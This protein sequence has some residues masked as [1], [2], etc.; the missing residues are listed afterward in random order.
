M[1]N[2]HQKSLCLTQAFA[3]RPTMPTKVSDR[4]WFPVHFRVFQHITAI[5]QRH[6]QAASEAYEN[7]H[8]LDHLLDSW[9]QEID[10]CSPSHAIIGYDDLLHDLSLIG[11]PAPPRLLKHL[12]NI[13]QGSSDAHQ[14][15][16]Q[17]CER[18]GFFHDPA[19]QHGR[20][21]AWTRLWPGSDLA[22]LELL[23]K[24][25]QSEAERDATLLHLIVCN[26]DRSLCDR[27]RFALLNSVLASIIFTGDTVEQW[28]M[29]PLADQP[30]INGDLQGVSMTPL[31]MAFECGSMVAIKVLV[32]WGSSIGVP[33]HGPQ[34]RQAKFTSPLH[35]AA[36]KMREKE[37]FGPDYA[38]PS[39]FL[40]FLERY[41]E[42][43]DLVTLDSNGQMYTEGLCKNQQVRLVYALLCIELNCWLL[44]IS[45][46]FC[47]S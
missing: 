5:V 30:A 34:P 37:G 14:W 9:K 12:R 18:T 20:S 32:L 45:E 27:D 4:L 13:I 21:E 17:L 22:L 23:P 2:V 41:A 7:S 47:Q 3:E 10:Q 35:V 11:P 46:S 42:T 44:F 24:L 39:S 31:A 1:P 15:S 40:P 28:S 33:V 16:Q 29:L 36:R 8:V 38:D 25:K 6:E 26:S 43:E 19:M